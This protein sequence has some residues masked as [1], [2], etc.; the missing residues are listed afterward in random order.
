MKGLLF[1]AENND[2]IVDRN[3]TDLI[4]STP[5]QAVIFFKWLWPVIIYLC[6]KLH[7]TQTEC[8]KIY[9][10]AIKVIATCRTPAEPEMQTGCMIS[11]RPRGLGKAEAVIQFSY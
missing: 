11:P 10:S 4:F 8:F 7:F 2:Y 9:Q 6:F 3:D 1:V 5:K